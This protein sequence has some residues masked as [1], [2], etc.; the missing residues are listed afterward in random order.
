[1]RER[2]RDDKW[3]AIRYRIINAGEDHKDSACDGLYELK[4]PYSCVTKGKVV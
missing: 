1:M 2:E 3:N 4:T